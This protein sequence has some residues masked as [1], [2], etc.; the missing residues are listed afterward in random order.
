MR[1]V[2]CIRSLVIIRITCLLNLQLAAHSWRRRVTLMP[3][4]PTQFYYFLVKRF[5]AAFRLTTRRFLI[6]VNRNH[7]FLLS[8]ILRY[9]LII[10]VQLRNDLRSEFGNRLVR[11]VFA[12]F[13]DAELHLLGLEIH[14][15]TEHFIGDL[16]VKTSVDSFWSFAFLLLRNVARTVTFGQ[17][18]LTRSLDLALALKVEHRVPLDNR[19]AYPL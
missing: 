1:W 5:I 7:D 15:V 19:G 10:P 13:W 6:R 4:F 17:Q 18:K 3:Q 16:S 9:K 12:R 2:T 8:R 14:A 11:L